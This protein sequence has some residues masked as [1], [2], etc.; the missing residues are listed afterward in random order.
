MQMDVSNAFLHGDLFEDVYMK[1]PQ[2][3]TNLGSRIHPYERQFSTGTSSNLVGKLKKSLYGLKRAPRNWFDKL[4]F[5]LLKLSFQ[6]SKLDNRLFFNHSKS[7]VLVVLVY[8]DDLLIC[9]SF[10]HDIDIS[11]QYFH[12]LFT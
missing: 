5:T 3:C 4:S 9:G 6:Q 7:S 12:L 11:K 8:V 2:G 1:I 10:L